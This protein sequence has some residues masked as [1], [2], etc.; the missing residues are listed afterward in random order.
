MRLRAGT[1]ARLHQRAE[2]G[3]ALRH[4]TRERRGNLGVVEQRLIMFPLGLGGCEHAFGGLQVRFRR[5]HLCGR[6]ESLALGIVHFLLRHQ[7][8]LRLRNAVQ[9]VELQLKHFLLGL[10]AVQFVLCVWDLGSGILDRGVVLFHL[11]LQFGNFQTS[12]GP[13]SPARAIHS[14]RS[15]PLRSRIPWRNTSISWKG[16]SSEESVKVRPRSFLPIFTTPTETSVELEFNPGSPGSLAWTFP[17]LP[18]EAKTPAAA[19]LRPNNRNTRV[20]ELI[21]LLS[22]PAKA[23]RN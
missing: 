21:D 11:Q 4:D 18:Q 8:G 22:C 7:A 14:R 12:R 20:F 23:N 2:I 16:T 13:G 19:T 15:G 5:F 10:H 3:E 6:R 9:P 17:E 1:G